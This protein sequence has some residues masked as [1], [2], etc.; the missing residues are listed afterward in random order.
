MILIPSEEID[1]WKG[2]KET[3]T[4]VKNIN[5]QLAKIEKFFSDNFLLSSENTYE[6]FMIFLGVIENLLY[7][8]KS[9]MSPDRVRNF[10]D[11][12]LDCFST[13]I[14]KEL[15]SYNFSD[16]TIQ[17]RSKVLEFIRSIQQVWDKI[18]FFNKEYFKKPLEFENT[19][20]SK[21]FSRLNEIY[22]IKNLVNEIN[23]LLPDVNIDG[24]LADTLKSLNTSHSNKAIDE[25]KEKL[26]KSL[27]N[28]EEDILKKLKKD[29]FVSDMHILSILREMQSWKGIFSQP[30]IIEKT[31]PDRSSLI[32][33]LIEYI[34]SVKSTFEKKSQENFEEVNIRENI[35]NVSEKISWII[36]AY[37]L[38]Q[39]IEN[40]RKL[41]KVLS[42]LKE[43]K[44][45][46]DL[47]DDTN[48]K[49][50][51]YIK[52]NLSDWKKQFN[53]KEEILPK[54]W[55]DI[56]EIDQKTSMLKVNFSEKLFLFLQD[57]RNLIE[58]G[59]VNNVKDL[60]PLNEEGK[61]IYKEAV[62]LKQIANFYN[63]L[64]SQV[65]KS[66]KPMLVQCARTFESNLK[67]ISD[68]NKLKNENFN[69]EN[70]VFLLQNAAN[71]LNVEIRRLKKAHSTVLDYVCQLLNYDLIS[72]KVKWKELLKKSR[73]IVE[74]ICEKYTDEKMTIEW[75]NH[76]NIQLYKVLKIQYTLSLEKFFSN[77]PEI[78]CQVL[79]KNKNLEFSPSTED[80]K[81]KVLKEI[82]SLISLPNLVLGFTSNFEF[83][84]IINQNVASLSK[85]YNQVNVNHEIKLGFDR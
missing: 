61:K 28:V 49:I 48:E 55:V 43:F 70:F 66:Q 3:N 17:I 47:C 63:S 54:S 71:D 82:K 36:W 16:N 64:S 20:M 85:L 68:K 60:L 29:I 72:N 27:L 38:R 26:E 33:K 9:A 83:Q 57:I 78:T 51:V 39:K 46:T 41:S 5:T 40:V 10:L 59:F 53:N 73:K 2:S 34:E 18:S 11:L 80:L 84:N 77:V 79:V 67:F 31:K 22:D 30:S 6:T 42:D 19:Y 76:W 52:E 35:S 58:F 14:N 4:N 74:E 75:R 21:L 24:V 8:Q 32:S 65:I 62:S 69:L 12:C 15:L 45:F 56:L 50:N 23:K 81:V 1:Y 37:T 13:K 25:I 7:E 44:K